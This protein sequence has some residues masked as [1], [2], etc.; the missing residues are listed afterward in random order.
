MVSLIERLHCTC[1]FLFCFLPFFSFFLSLGP[2]VCKIKDGQVE[3][4]VNQL[5]GNMFSDDER[6][7][8]ISSVGK[9]H[10]KY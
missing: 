1:T 4:I 10:L 9:N 8:D 6:L 2:L 5:C 3:V 7:R